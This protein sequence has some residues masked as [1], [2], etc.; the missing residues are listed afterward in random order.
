MP[1]NGGGGA[2]PTGGRGFA[3]NAAAAELRNYCTPAA[4]D[5]AQSGEHTRP[6]PR[7]SRCGRIVRPHT[8]QL[9][10]G[11]SRWTGIEALTRSDTRSVAL[12]VLCEI[13]L[14]N[15]L[16]CTVASCRG[17]GRLSG[18]S[19]AC[20]PCGLRTGERGVWHLLV[21]ENRPSRASPAAAGEPC[22][23]RMRS[24]YPDGAEGG[25]SRNGVVVRPLGPVDASHCGQICGPLWTA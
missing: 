11:S 13:F 18:S 1:S 4:Q 16:R 14:R 12:A 23:V 7:T 9:S 19:A 10:S 22:V 25:I 20:V 21:P 17:H 5:R 6:S 2:A 8:M 15:Q 24:G 3:R